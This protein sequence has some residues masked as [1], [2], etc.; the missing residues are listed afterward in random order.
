MGKSEG[1]LAPECYSGEKITITQKFDLYSL[2]II[3]IEMLTGKKD[4]VTIENA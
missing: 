2:G 3:I 1:Y 4:P